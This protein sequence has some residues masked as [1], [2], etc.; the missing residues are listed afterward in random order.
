MPDSF[1]TPPNSF[2]Q[3]VAAHFADRPSLRSVTAR[4]AFEALADRYPWIRTNHPGLQSLE[5]M[6]IVHAPTGDGAVRQSDLLD[7]L[8]THF[9]DGSNLS[10]AASDQFSLAPPAIFRPQPQA[11]T[12]DLRMDVVNQAFDDMLTTLTESLQQAQV[13]FWNGCEGDSGVSRLRWLEQMIKAALLSTLERQGLCEDAKRLLYGWVAEDSSTPALQGLQVSLQKGGDAHHLVS[14]DLLMIA[15]RDEGSLVLWCQPSGT[16]R[17]FNDAPAFA[18]ALRDELADQHDFDTLSWACTPV[19]GDAFRYQAGQLLN[20]ALQGIERVQLCSITQVSEL[21]RLYNQLCDPSL[22]FPEHTCIDR[23]APAIPLPAW[24]AK[25]SASDRFDYHRA[26]LAL[27]ARQALAT[28]TTAPDDFEDLQ[29]YTT[30]RLREQ[31]TADHPGKAVP[32]SDQLLISISQVVEIS[33]L[34]PARLEP[35]KTVSLTELAISRLQ[36]AQHEVATAVTAAGSQ[37]V[38]GWLNLDYINRLVATLDVGAQYPLYIHQKLQDPVGRDQRI[39]RFAGEWR[40][41]LLLDALQARIVGH[42]SEQACQALMLFCRNTTTATGPVRVA[43]LAFHCVRGATRANRVH[44]MFVIVVEQP[45]TWILYRPLAARRR[46]RVY[47]SEAL[48]MADVRAAGE[49]QQS[50]LAWLDD[51]DRPIYDNGGFTRPHLHPQLSELGDLL[52]AGAVLTEH[53]LAQMRAPATLAFA[54]WS[55]DLHTQLLQAHAEAMVLLA[56]RQSVSNAQLRWAMVVQL[57]W[58]VF[59]TVTALLRGPAATVIWLV[60]TVVSLKT[61]LSALAKGSPEEKVL[62]ASDLLSNIAMLLVHVHTTAQPQRVQPE[63]N[64]LYLGGPSPRQAGSAAR[65]E[66]PQARAWQDPSQLP[67]PAPYKVSAWGNNQRIGNLTSTARNALLELRANVDLQGLVAQQQGRLRG[68]CKL[69][70]RYYVKLEDTPYEVEESYTG[71]RII[72]PDTSAGD[73]Q[74]LGGAWDGYHIVGRERSRGP[75]LARWNGEWMIDLRLAGGMPRSRKGVLDENRATI[76]A[77]QEQRKRNDQAILKNET[78]IE[79]YLELTKPYDDAARDVRRALRE[80]PGI[81]RSDLPETLQEQVRTVQTMR[82]EVRPHLLIISLTYEK[83]ADLLGSQVRLFTQMSEPRFARLDPRSTSAVGRSQWAEQLLD[84]D[85]HLF[86]RLLDLTDYEVLRQQSAQLAKLPFGQEQGLLYLAYRDNVAAAYATHKRVLT[87]SERLDQNIALALNDTTLQFKDKQ[88]KL[89]KIIGQRHY[90]TVISRGQV[91]SDLAQLVVNREQLTRENFDELLR[92]QAGL[93][94]R[95]FQAALLSHDGL[96]AENLPAEEQVEILGNAV[97]EYQASLGKAN[98]LLSM[99]EPALDTTRL[100]QYISELTALKSAAEHD[101]SNALLARQSGTPAQPRQLTYRRRPGRRKL[102][103]TVKGRTILAEYS[104]EG[105]LATQSDP[106]TQQTVQYQPRGAQWEP[107]PS[108]APPRSNA[109]LRRVG[110]SLLAQKAGKLA[111]AARYSKEPNSLADLMDW[112]IQDMDD[113]ARQLTAGPPE[114][115]ALA[116]QLNEAVEGL[117]AEKRRLLTDA[118]LN[119]RYP[120]SKALRYL[121]QQGQIEITLSNARKRLKANDYLDVYS[122][123]RKQPRQMLWEAHFHYTSAQAAARAFAKGH[124]KFWE[125]RAMSREEKLERSLDPAERIHIYR[126]DLRLEQI[127]GAFPFPPD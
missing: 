102:I 24:L 99:D 103:R 54:A 36:P 11:P 111:L 6:S 22:A 69:D 118:Y 74:A 86:H 66:Q 105:Q 68:L 4:A 23:Q 101:L 42:L 40:S 114:G 62:A 63:K 109:Y 47:S 9:L 65:Q 92:M 104:A 78:F 91:I 96:A 29:Q 38:E 107:V 75:W 15:E 97:R 10:L 43:P 57:G 12:I 5:G 121:Q 106:V 30:R 3:R 53:T 80:H 93:R 51:A 8:L 16:V 7:T 95:G 89:E 81:A 90:S 127:E 61:D 77:L 113:I 37:P 52:G 20:G 46:L 70:E 85:L 18:L 112:Q 14:A 35:L 115:Q 19:Q 39:Q 124:L 120:D 73:W 59:N 83:Q 60:A 27:A 117:Q 28:G 98:Y 87:V 84:T 48:L 108:A 13:S 100:E 32:A 64:E 79:R 21:Q 17:S 71:V 58:M 72:G 126:G 55:D 44:G 76:V 122:I 41:S 110:A 116:A 56:S 125:P 50:I 34:G 45:R 31:M 82:N 119:T 25:A 123:Y 49:L 26:M 67:A 2:S 94:D 88:S 33:S 1:P